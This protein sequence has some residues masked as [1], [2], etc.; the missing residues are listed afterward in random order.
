MNYDYDYKIIAGYAR[1]IHANIRTR[2]TKNCLANILKE[3]EAFKQ[4]KW[5]EECPC[6]KK[7]L[8][9]MI[10]S[11][12]FEKNDYIYTGKIC[13]LNNLNEYII[14]DFKD[15]DNH[16]G[17]LIEESSNPEVQIIIKLFMLAYIA[18][19][20]IGKNELF[21]LHVLYSD[22]FFFKQIKNIDKLTNEQ[23]GILIDIRNLIEEAKQ[24]ELTKTY[25]MDVMR[26]STA[27]IF[28]KNKTFC[29]IRNALGK[30]RDVFSGGMEEA[31]SLVVD[32]LYDNYDVIVS[33]VPKAA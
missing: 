33:R 23:L 29:L 3:T 13:S 9:E 8:L 22:K 12:F 1:E 32:I 27:S 17:Y 28:A 4:N 7:E 20:S 15:T 14:T 5:M 10:V 21:A 16:F 19:Q 2:E 25:L 11:T 30:Y 24:A 6:L 31:F 18:N 26:K